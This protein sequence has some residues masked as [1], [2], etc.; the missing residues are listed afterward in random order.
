MKLWIKAAGFS[1]FWF[2]GLTI[3]NG[4]FAAW[5]FFERD[6][7]AVG[8]QGGLA[9]LML[10]VAVSGTHS[11]HSGLVR[12]A[13]VDEAMNQAVRQVIPNFTYSGPLGSSSITSTWGA[14]PSLP[15]PSPPQSLVLDEPEEV[16]ELVSAWR[17]WNL[18][19]HAVDGLRLRG[20][21]NAVWD[22][23]EFEATCDL[24]GLTKH[25]LNP[26][27]G[28]Q[29]HGLHELRR[30]GMLMPSLYPQHDFSAPGCGLYAH[31]KSVVSVVVPSPTTVL[32]TVALSGLVVPGETGYRAQHARIERLYVL[33]NPED[34]GQEIAC[35]EPLR[36][37]YGVPVR[38]VTQAE[39]ELLTREEN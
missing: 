14:W 6:W 35:L 23:A 18:D 1:G 2:A 31:R 22:S 3:F 20:M 16:E 26:E 15:A 11:R 4:S 29:E 27:V 28:D 13:R 5:N 34:R 32:G 36:K 19:Y 39:L 12:E 8:I 25:L 30:S 9:V 17:L 7:W 37:R 38:A 21:H 33:V 10:A 24:G